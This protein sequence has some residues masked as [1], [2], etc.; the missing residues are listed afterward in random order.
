MAKIGVFT[1]WKN[2]NYGGFLQALATQE[3]LKKLGNQPEMVDL[4]TH[5]LIFSFVV[6]VLYFSFHK[7]L[8]ASFIQISL[9]YYRIYK[10]LRK[11]FTISP[12]RLPWGTHSCEKLKRYDIL[13]CGSDQIWNPDYLVPDY[14]LPEAPEEIPKMSYASSIGNADIPE[15]LQG[16]YKKFLDRFCQISVRE[17]S[18][19]VAL[20][21]VLD[22]EACWV[23][24][25]TLLLTAE[26]WED[27]LGIKNAKTTGKYMFCY[28]LSLLP[29]EKYFLLMKWAKKHKQKIFLYVEHN[30][31]IRY[32]SNAKVSWRKIFD[33]LR[34][35][36][37]LLFSPWIKI[38]QS[39]SVEDFV[40]A[41][42]DSEVMISDSFHALM[43]A[44]I[45]NKNIK[46]ILPQDRLRMS[47]RITDFCK[48]IQ[49]K[50]VI[51]NDFIPEMFVEKSDFNN[52]LLQT[53]IYDSKQWLD[54][55]IKTCEKK[56]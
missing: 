41:I 36:M 12:F 23:V 44:T 14:L 21:K 56:S 4:G 20:N 11:K 9:R 3:Y 13:L 8:R 43:F 52:D 35:N 47:P 15:E 31:G 53:W 37:V 19:A 27:C 16:V 7:F 46:I 30:A 49:Y 17:A 29:V 1:W 38:R 50:N 10:T 51:I 54:N 26:Q 2:A 55:A 5:P 39:A 6:R 24:D 33:V 34:W 48:K 25:P 28:T 42:R 45:F 32:W 18:G 22:K 40:S